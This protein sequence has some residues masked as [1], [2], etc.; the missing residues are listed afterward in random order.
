MLCGVCGRA[1][2]TARTAVARP[3][4]AKV[5]SAVSVA[6]VASVAE[7]VEA[8]AFEAPAVDA[9][10]AAQPEPE[11]PFAEPTPEPMAR[12]ILQFST[13]ES[14]TVVGTGIIGRNPA[15]EPG[16]YFDLRIP[17]VDPSKSVSKT[18][19]E[20]GQDD[21][22]FWV[23]DRHSGNGTSIRQPDAPQVRCDAGKRY[24]VPRGARVDIGDQFFIV[25]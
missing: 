11:P 5:A 6:S 2:S 18:H 3:P 15:P 7:P 9:P 24:L 12:F 25:S 17:I 1:V 4:V 19:L 22:N 16:E 21:G 8:P 10:A 23:N 13:G 14:V 20:F